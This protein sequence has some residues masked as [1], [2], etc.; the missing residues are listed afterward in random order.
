MRALVANMAVLALAACRDRSPPPP[1][2]RLCDASASA[3]APA[4]GWWKVE[5]PCPEGTTFK[6]WTRGDKTEIGC[7]ASDGELEGPWTLL[8]AKG[9][10]EATVT[11]RD[12]LRH[13]EF[14]GYTDGVKTL[15]VPHCEG[16]RHGRLTLWWSTSGTLLEEGTYVEHEREGEWRTWHENGQLSRVQNFRKDLAHGE[17]QQWD[18]AGRLLGRFTMENGTGLWMDWHE[19][20]SVATEGKLRRGKKVGRWVSRTDDG[21][22]VSDETYPE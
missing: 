2:P 20:G 8:D 7:T 5:T 9:R 1:A 17:F 19:N 13:G 4:Y 16:N 15:A 18:D 3:P 12:G 22:I 14:V 21:R 6:Q 11:H 10:V